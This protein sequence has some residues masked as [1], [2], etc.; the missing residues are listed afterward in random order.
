MVFSVVV[1]ILTGIYMATFIIFT[2]LFKGITGPQTLF[3]SFLAACLI[4]SLFQP[5]LKKVQTSI[6]RKFFRQ[7]VNR[8][9]KLYELSRE[10]ITHTT[11]EEMAE[12]L[13]HVLGQALYLKS[14]AIY[15]RAREGGEFIRM[16]Q[17]QGSSLPERL[18]QENILIRYF[19]DHPQPFIQEAPSGIGESYDTRTPA[20]QEE[21]A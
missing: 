17:Q 13:M 2:H 11:P 9:Q 16:A 18:N 1:S 4:T 21:A 15:L 14:G 10:V 20:R 3:S 6:D 19:L 8:E 12:A 5:L 7:Y